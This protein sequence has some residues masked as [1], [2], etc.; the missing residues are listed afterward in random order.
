MTHVSRFSLRNILSAI[1]VFTFLLTA[2]APAMSAYP[3]REALD[4]A[5]PAAPVELS[6]VS[7]Y[8]VEESAGSGNFQSPPADTERLVI[9]NGNLSIV[10]H[11]PR[12]SFAIFDSE[13]NTWTNQRVAYDIPGVQTRMEQFRLPERHI[14]RLSGGW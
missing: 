1:F 14:L 9:K 10:D 4:A 6:V 7:T 12:A 2:C 3:E 5:P 13:Q 11:D 8:A